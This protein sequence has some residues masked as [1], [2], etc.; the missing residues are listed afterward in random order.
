MYYQ[1]F[2]SSVRHQRQLKEWSQNELSYRWGKSQAYI[3]KIEKGYIKPSN[4]MIAELENLFNPPADWLEGKLPTMT[5]ELPHDIGARIKRLRDVRQLTRIDAA[6]LLNISPSTLNGIERG[7][8]RPS[9]EVLH[10]IYMFFLPPVDWLVVDE[11]PTPHYDDRL[12]T[13]CVYASRMASLSYEQRIRCQD[14][15]DKYVWANENG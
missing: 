5:V 14:V 8:T 4:E 11:M 9:D 12:T 3:S 6:R 7:V 10:F 2:G 1:G 15:I 13:I